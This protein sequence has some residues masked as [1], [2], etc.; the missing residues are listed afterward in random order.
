MNV[1]RQPKLGNNDWRVLSGR[2]DP[3]GA[4]FDGAGVNFA[5]FAAHAEMVELCLFGTDGAREI[6]RVALPACTHEVWHAYL[7]DARPGQ[8]YGYRVHGPYEPERGH[9]HNPH[10]LLLD[11]YA[12][13][14]A[15]RYRWTEAH[16]GYRPGQA[17]GDLVMDRRDNA[18]SMFRARVVD[19]AFDWG[20]DRLPRTPWAETVICEAHVKGYSRLNPAV[21]ERLR[22]TYAGL[23]H[24]A[25]IARL[26]AC[27]ST[28]VEL[29]PIQ[30]F[31]DER[32]LAVADRVNY[33]GYN[34]LAYF[35]PEARYAGGG[36]PVVEFR[37]MVKALHAAGLE[38]ILD[39]VFNHTAE[40][41]ALGPTLSFRGIDN[42]SYYRLRAGDPRHYAD[43]SG[44]G[45]TLNLNHPR[46][47]QLVM[48]AL[49]YWAG[50]M[51]VDG[52]RFDLATALALGPTGFDAR[53]T[54]L[55]CVRQDPLLST[56]KLIAEPWDIQTWQTGHF[57]AP[58]AEWND[59]YRDAVRSFWLT[60][61]A[62]TGE[63]ARRLAGSS[64]LFRHS[65]RRP[66]ASINYVTAHDGFTLADLV[67]YERKHNEAN[68]Q[69]NA[70]GSNDNRSNH[71]G[72]EG[73][74]DDSS[75]Q[76]RRGRLMRAMLATL[77][78]SQ[79]VP[80]LPA[81]DECGRTQHGNNNAYCQDSPLTWIDWD[82]SDAGLADFVA[83]LA[84]L[85]ATHP[86]LRRET[87][88]DGSP[89]AQGEPDIAWIAR[90]GGP[91]QPADW[92][93]PG[94]RAFGF[95][96]GRADADE[97]AV[98]VLLNAA[99]AAAEFELPPPPHGAWR[100]VL[101]SAGQAGTPMA[102]MQTV[103]AEGVVILLAAQPAVV[104]HG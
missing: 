80:M 57:P 81:G 6:A 36:D 102:G 52:F 40:G 15:G 5:L 48:D 83:S 28:A 20:G 27:G 69:D 22:G 86:A 90:H 71:C 45:N 99:A 7:P 49:R 54:F 73:P 97:T 53:A 88:F 47:L 17:R 38:V 44:C 14:L 4:T 23:A 76:A 104:Q 9:R 16:L 18:Q 93:D 96:L 66:Q 65:C 35:A 3:L 79:G 56:I 13:A 95:L 46:V 68:G 51:H 12:R 63:L 32:M 11:P 92:D 94:N 84:A 21:P 62:S 89:T 24:P 31:I 75:I 37:A 103:P 74:S 43:S 55:D 101:D 100:L 10:K 19:P 26:V 59:R 34:P 2:P 61:G 50:E 67:A 91:M 42:A 25:S 58:F 77:F 98:L 70:D 8:I 82:N 64:D 78:V 87:W 85:R 39:V 72:V 29:L 30:A 41:D 1:P 60:G 33:W